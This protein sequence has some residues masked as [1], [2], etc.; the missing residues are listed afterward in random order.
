MLLCFPVT[1]SF[2][3]QLEIGV[4]PPR[5]AHCESEVLCRYTEFESMAIL[6]NQE[7]LVNHGYIVGRMVRPVMASA[8]RLD[9]VCFQTIEG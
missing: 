3:T 8:E 2:F 7:I 5:L 9:I 4:G 1:G 6:I